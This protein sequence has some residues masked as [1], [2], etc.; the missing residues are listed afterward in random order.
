MP[1]RNIIV[2]NNRLV[3]QKFRD[4]SVLDLKIDE[5]ETVREVVLAVRDS[6]H[7]GHRLISHPLS[8]NFKPER[9]PLKSIVI[10]PPE[11]ELDHYSLKLIERTIDFYR[12][13]WPDSPQLTEDSLVRDFARIDFELIKNFTKLNERY[14]NHKKEGQYGT[15][16]WPH[17][18]RRCGV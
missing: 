10:S 9:N 15:G 7:R 2:T 16:T 13:K 17:I 3:L 14:N 4:K 1:N 6:I 5:R 11:D 18:H 8:G 12:G